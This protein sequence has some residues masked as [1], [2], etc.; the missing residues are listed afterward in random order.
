MAAILGNGVGAA[1]LGIFITAAESFAPVHD[2]LTLDAGIG[3]LSGKTTAA[4]VVWL[5]AWMALHLLWRKR[6]VGGRPVLFA[7]GILMG[8]GLLGTFPPVYA[9]IAHLL[10]G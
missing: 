8:I 3:P 5:A 7:T 6:D 1:A 2:A 9:N 4:I 10:G